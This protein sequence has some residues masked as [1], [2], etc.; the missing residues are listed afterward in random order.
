MHVQ[1]LLP[2]HGWSATLIHTNTG[3]YAGRSGGLRPIPVSVESLCAYV[4]MKMGSSHL[5]VRGLYPRVW[6]LLA[7]LLII[8]A[9]VLEAVANAD[10][11]ADGV[12]SGSWLTAA[13]PLHLGPPSLCMLIGIL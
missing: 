11:L 12:A 7:I 10:G 2:L 6:D 9:K 13:A 5:D 1:R 4:P 3:R 8:L